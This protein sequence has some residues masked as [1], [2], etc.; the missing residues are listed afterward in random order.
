MRTGDACETSG[1]YRSTCGCR[2][3]MT[4]PRGPPAPLCPVCLRPVVWTL[5]EQ[6]PEGAGDLRRPA[7]DRTPRRSPP[8]R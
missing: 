2:V 5:Q 3:E 8:P 4:I 1:T 7:P 6:P